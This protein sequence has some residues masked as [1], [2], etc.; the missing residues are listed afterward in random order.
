M[1]NILNKK[2]YFPVTYTHTKNKIK[3][4]WNFSNYATKSS[5]QK[6][7]VVGTSKFAEKVVLASLKS[8]VDELF[9]DK[10]KAVPVDLSKLR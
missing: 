7:T 8:D 5:S 6:A 4:E 2:S 1:K 3:V 9:I 10:L